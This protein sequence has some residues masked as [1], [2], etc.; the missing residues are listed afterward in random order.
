M[1][2]PE[3]NSGWAIVKAFDHKVV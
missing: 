1:V 3:G 2:N